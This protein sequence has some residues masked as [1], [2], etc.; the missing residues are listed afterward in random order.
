LVK[1]TTAHDFFRGMLIFSRN[2]AHIHS[3]ELSIKNEEGKYTPEFTSSLKDY[4]LY[5]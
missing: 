5:L 2:H 1:Q 4:Y 3:K